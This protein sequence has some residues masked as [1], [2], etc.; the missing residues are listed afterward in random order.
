MQK[1]IALVALLPV[2]SV[3][4]RFRGGG[5]IAWKTP[6]HR[7]Y[8]TAAI[9]F[10][11]LFGITKWQTA[12]FITLQYLLLVLLPWG[13]WYTIGHLP[14]EISGLPD[15][16][17]RFLERITA[18][19]G[20]SGSDYA[21]F[22]LRNL[23]CL[24]PCA[25]AAYMTRSIIPIASAVLLSVIIVESYRLSWRYIKEADTPTAMAEWVSGAA[26]GA[27]IA[28]WLITN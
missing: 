10:V 1:A 17:E 27:V 23:V 4:H 7:R 18:S 15:G 19:L 9:L 28:I 16:F 24:S 14:R 13:R 22:V 3:L 21:A 2:L 12:V 5:L 6:I 8:I 25:I 26:I 11:L 20:R